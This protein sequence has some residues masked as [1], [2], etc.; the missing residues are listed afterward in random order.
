MPAVIQVELLVT[1]L[2]RGKRR[3]D[4]QDMELAVDLMAVTSKTDER[5]ADIAIIERLAKKLDLSTVENLKKETIA[6]SNVAKERGR[7][8]ECV[9]QIVEILNKFKQV[10][11]MEVTDVIEDPVKTNLSLKSGPLVIPHEFLC[12]I[13]LEVMRDPVIIASGQVIRMPVP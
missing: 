1:Q 4:T 13:T 3:K 8:L 12:P 5:K 6:I 9:E 10:F 7:T 2:R 11:G